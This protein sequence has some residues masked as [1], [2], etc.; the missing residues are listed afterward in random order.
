MKASKTHDCSITSGACSRFLDLDF[1]GY[2]I[3]D[4]FPS[5]T[6]LPLSLQS[7]MIPIVSL[8]V[9]P[10]RIKEFSR[11]KLFQLLKCDGLC[12]SYTVPKVHTL[13]LVLIFM[14]VEQGGVSLF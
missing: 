14:G 4:L 7:S 12:A 13:S 11:P 8:V 3:L 10:V 1:P 9:K 5:P 6:P 2:W